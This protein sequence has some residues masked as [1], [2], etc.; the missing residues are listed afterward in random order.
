MYSLESHYRGDSNVYTKYAFQDKIINISMICPKY[1]VYIDGRIYENISQGTLGR[2][3]I[4]HGKRAIGVRAI[5]VSL[6]T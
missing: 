4:I 1:T 5:E 6:R 2:V 3:R